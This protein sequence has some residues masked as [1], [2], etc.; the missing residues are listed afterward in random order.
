M[1]WDDLKGFKGVVGWMI[2]YVL[3][4]SGSSQSIEDALSFTATDLT[5]A[6]SLWSYLAIVGVSL[7]IVYFLCDLNKILLQSQGNINGKILF[8]PIMK[9]GIGYY[10]LAHGGK[11]VGWIFDLN[12]AMISY[13]N[14][15]IVMTSVGTWGVPDTTT[16]AII[17]MVDNLGFYDACFLAA[18]LIIVLMLSYIPSLVMLYNAYARKLEMIIRVGI[19]PVALGDIFKGTDGTA[20]KWLK[21]FLALSLYGVCMIMV[22]KIGSNLQISYLLTKFNNEA[23]NDLTNVILNVTVVGGLWRSLQFIRNLAGLLVIA[24][25]EIGACSLLKQAC[26]EVLGVYP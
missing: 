23:L 14:T 2:K 13:V 26:K 10:F 5:I 17:E 25:A 12:N 9:F 15:Q 21:Q 7:L 11:I 24:I 19:T 16:Q 20:V 6:N 22:I 3:D 8:A 1:T 18:M 4:A